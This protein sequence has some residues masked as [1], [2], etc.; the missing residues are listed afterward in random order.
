MS[1]PLGGDDYIADLLTEWARWRAGENKAG[2]G[3]ARSNA[4]SPSPSG[5]YRELMP[6]G[7][8]NPD[9]PRLDELVKQLPDLER[10]VVMALYTQPG[11]L[12]QHAQRFGLSRQALGELQRAAKRLLGHQ[13]RQM[14]ARQ[15]ERRTETA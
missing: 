13:L 8:I 2:L 1:G 12:Q 14:H 15:A 11:T 10:Q 9:I 5:G 4:Y 6:R 7:L 3:Y